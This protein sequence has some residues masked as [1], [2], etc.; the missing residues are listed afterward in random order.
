MTFALRVYKADALESTIFVVINV[1][2]ML[3]SYK[4]VGNTVDS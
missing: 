2:E 4:Y 1:A 3:N